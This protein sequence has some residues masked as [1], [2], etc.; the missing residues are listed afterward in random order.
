MHFV[1]EQLP[2]PPRRRSKKLQTTRATELAAR[3]A[4]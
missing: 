3:R 4:A 2:L 1:E